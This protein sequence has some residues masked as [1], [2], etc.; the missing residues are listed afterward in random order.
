VSSQDADS[1]A[2]S[3]KPSLG[4]DVAIMRRFKYCVAFQ[5]IIAFLLRRREHL[6][7]MT[8]RADAYQNFR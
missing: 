5:F 3:L 4:W 8:E 1:H 7:Q 6:R 2:A